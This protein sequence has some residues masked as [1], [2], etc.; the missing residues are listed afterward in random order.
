MHCIRSYVNWETNSFKGWDSVHTAC[1]KCKMKNGN[2]HAQRENKWI[3]EWWWFVELTKILFVKFYSFSYQTI[4]CVFNCNVWC[5]RHP[6]ISRP[7]FIFVSRECVKIYENHFFLSFLINTAYL[8]AVNIQNSFFP[9]FPLEV[10]FAN[11]Q[12]HTIS[13]PTPASSP[14]I[15]TPPTPTTRFGV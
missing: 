4:C 6:L 9:H 12:T 7:A 8:F 14:Q 1:G 13:H 11:E 10:L 15:N 2:T 5:C 3:D